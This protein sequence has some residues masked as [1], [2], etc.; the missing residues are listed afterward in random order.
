MMRRRDRQINDQKEIEE[1][2][3]EGTIC[4]LAMSQDNMPYV[5][6]LMYVYDNNAIYFHCAEV[7]LKLDILR[8]NNQVC[9][10]VQFTAPDIVLNSERPCDWGIAYKS[11]IGFGKTMF[12]EDEV[13]K[14]RIYDKLVLKLAPKE[15]VHEKDPYERKKIVGTNI[16]KVEIS[17][18]TGK[19][20]DGIKNV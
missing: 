7:G 1:I 16:I 20:W 6:P 11:V 17:S 13:A 10:E 12:I 15:Y 19:K 2:L 4:H 8:D 18:M 3:R 9:F 5:V 14:K